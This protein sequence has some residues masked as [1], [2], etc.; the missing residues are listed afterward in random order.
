MGGRSN[1]KEDGDKCRLFMNL[2]FLHF[3]NI[4]STDQWLRKIQKEAFHFNY[5]YK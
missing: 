5:I 2:L 4:M 1:W 3:K